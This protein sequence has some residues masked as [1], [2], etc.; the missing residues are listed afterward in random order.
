MEACGG[1]AT[2]WPIPSGTLD[3]VQTPLVDG[4]G[5]PRDGCISP[6]ER[7]HA[8]S[9]SQKAKSPDDTVIDSRKIHQLPDLIDVAE[10]LNPETRIARAES[11]RRQFRRLGSN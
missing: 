10:R 1:Y 7:C 8:V 5:F 2:S 11:N 6:R 3:E 9:P 4:P